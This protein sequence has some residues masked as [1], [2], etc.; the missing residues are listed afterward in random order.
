MINI[1]GGFSLQA[2][3]LAQVGVTSSAYVQ[4]IAPSENV[5]G[6]Y[7]S[8][9]VADGHGSVASWR[10]HTS[11]PANDTQG[12]ILAAVGGSNS[13]AQNPVSMPCAAVI[14]PGLGIYA[15][16]G[17]GASSVFYRVL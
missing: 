6:V 15:K 5:N 14:P 17:V 2:N 9:F 11:A 12:V 8:H 16:C 4:V 13:T 1:G 10:A 7:V 3:A